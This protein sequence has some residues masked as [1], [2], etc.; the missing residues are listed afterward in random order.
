M[1]EIL[2]LFA[3]NDELASVS[4]RTFASYGECAVFVNEL[5]NK[6]VVN[7]DYGFAFYT[8]EGDK[9]VGQCIERSE[10]EV[11]KNT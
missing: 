3:M 4:D 10:Y 6:D 9:F 5:V 8:E 11:E 1:L 7:S 2:L